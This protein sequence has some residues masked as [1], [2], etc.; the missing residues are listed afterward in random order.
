MEEV[1]CWVSGTLMTSCH[2]KAPHTSVHYSFHSY[3]THSKYVVICSF[4]PQLLSS[5]CVSPIML[6]TRSTEIYKMDRT[7]SSQRFYLGGVSD[8]DQRS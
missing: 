6:G 1:R 2:C 8:L 3:R 5:Y 4:A 7:L